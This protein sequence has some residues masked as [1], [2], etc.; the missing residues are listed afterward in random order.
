MC[1]LTTIIT[2]TTTTIATTTII[3]FLTRFPVS[4]QTKEVALPPQ[5]PPCSGGKGEK[6]DKSSIKDL[7]IFANENVSRVE[8]I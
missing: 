2:T 3:L 5:P 1:L 4:P 6:G 8:F 7:K